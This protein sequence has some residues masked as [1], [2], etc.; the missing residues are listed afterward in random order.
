[1][2]CRFSFKHMKTSEALVEYSEEKILGKIEKFSTKPI[3]AHITFSVDGHEHIAHCSVKGGDGFNI[4]VES[5]CADM[6]GSVDILIDKLEGQLK[7]QK[8]K[9][10]HHKHTHNIRMLKPKEYVSNDDCDSIPVDAGDLI[11]FERAKSK[12]A[13]G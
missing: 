13:N 9:L 2:Q 3:E 11:K 4:Q 8:E 10:K 6:Y 12:V 1:M 7:R 5:T